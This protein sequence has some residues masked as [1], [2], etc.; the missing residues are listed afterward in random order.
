MKVDEKIL[1]ETLPDL[2]LLNGT[3]SSGKTS[4]AKQ[5]QEDLPL[6]Y[7][8][9]SIDSVLYALPE[10]DLA[11]MIKGEAIHR[12]GYDYAQLV[13]GYHQC[14]PSLLS[15]GCRLIID[16]AWIDAQQVTELFGL[17]KGYRC[18]LVGVHCD[19]DVAK[20]R[21]VKRGDR[22]IGLAEHEFPLV[23]DTMRYDLQLDSSEQ[24]P[25][26]SSQKVLSYL[27]S[28]NHYGA[29]QATLG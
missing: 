20:E 22:A 26:Q 27:I 29:L 23:H 3:G 16:N 2:I 14:L 17:L 12:A 6:Q 19:L 21:E 9:F 8:N 5:L 1:A 4:I 24:S 11:H 7:L 18:C 10:S 15:S 25:I 13:D 28:N